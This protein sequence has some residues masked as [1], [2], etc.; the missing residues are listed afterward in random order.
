[1]TQK[2]IKNS[3][4]RPKRKIVLSDFAK[5]LNKGAK[6]T[7]ISK[8]KKTHIHIFIIGSQVSSYSNKLRE[9]WLKKVNKE[10]DLALNK[11]NED[12][13]LFYPKDMKCVYLLKSRLIYTYKQIEYHRK[14]KDFGKY[15]IYK[16]K[17]IQCLT[18][19]EIWKKY[20]VPSQD[21]KCK[22]V[23]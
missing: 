8:E 4:G 9:Y 6:G 7:Y 16:D 13:K 11:I 12:K 1:L 2:K 15:L 19:K 17:N 18:K 22:I 21:L 14:T 10:F 5:L 23:K 3:Q 20:K